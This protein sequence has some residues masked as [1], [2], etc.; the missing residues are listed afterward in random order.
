[1]IPRCALCRRVTFRRRR[2]FRND[3]VRVMSVRVCKECDPVVTA[4]DIGGVCNAVV[5]EFS[6]A[7]NTMT[8]V[9]A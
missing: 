5:A 8:R 9:A 3:G 4:A 1:M 7:W 2:S 6:T